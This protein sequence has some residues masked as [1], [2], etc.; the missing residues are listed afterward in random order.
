MKIWFFNHYAVPPSLYP[1]A[2]TYNFAKYLTQKNHSIKIFAASTVHNSAINLIKTNEK[3]KEETVD[4]IDY[5][6]LNTSN[7]HSNGFDRVKNMIQYTIGLL[8]IAK[9]YDN[10]DMIVASSVHPL[11]CVAGIIIAKRKKCPCIVEIADLWPKTLIDFGKISENSFISVLLYRLER[12]IYKKADSVIFTMEGG[13]DYIIE[14]HYNSGI[15]LSKIFYLNNGIDLYKFNHDKFCYEYN[16]VHLDSDDIFKVTYAG[17]LGEANAVSYIIEAARIIKDKGFDNIYI[18]IFGDGTQK[19]ILE[20]QCLRYDLNNTIFKGKIEKKYIS[21]ILSK[22][23][24]NIFTG[25]NLSIYKYGISLNKMF[26]Y[27]ASGKPTLSNINCGYDNI[28]KF[29][30]GLTVLPEDPEALADGIIKF[31][32]MNSN[33]YNKFSFNALKAAEYFDFNK[34][35]DELE[36]LVLRTLE[37]YK[38]KGENK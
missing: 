31:Y 8:R 30:C 38:L 33:E 19:K 34:L 1:L 11:A 36:G 15:D 2:R 21:N 37:Q 26:D 29:E 3:H 10:P 27:F 16:D 25:K 23:D 20:E 32:K 35:T 13:K 9:K 4:G 14:K 12:W 6:Y 17:S 5:I 22:G 24:L 28:K 7:Y 18:L